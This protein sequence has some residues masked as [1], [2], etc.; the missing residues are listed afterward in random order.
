MKNTYY[1]IHFQERHGSHV[2][3][4][5]YLLRKK[6]SS[7]TDK[8]IEKIMQGEWYAGEFS[9]YDEESFVYWFNNGVAVKIDSIKQLTLK[10]FNILS[11]YLKL[12][13]KIAA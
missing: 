5:P 1:I 6:R 9:H 11:K 12:T 3:N 8:D 10:D 13:R 7:V 2:S 4:V